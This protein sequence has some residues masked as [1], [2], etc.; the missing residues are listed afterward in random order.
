[1]LGSGLANSRGVAKDSEGSGL[2]TVGLVED[3]GGSIRGISMG[4]A[5]SKPGRR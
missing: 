4:V 2:R 3:E 1:M 5:R